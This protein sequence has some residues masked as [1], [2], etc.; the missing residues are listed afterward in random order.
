MFPTDGITF[1]FPL[2]INGRSRGAVQ[3]ALI[4]P[5]TRAVGILLLLVQYQ[6]L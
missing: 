6:D 1:K 4:P 2:V 3:G 5:P